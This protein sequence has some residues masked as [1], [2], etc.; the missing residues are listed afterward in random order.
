MRPLNRDT[1]PHL[2]GVAA[3][4]LREA[5]ATALTRLLAAWWGVELGDGCRFFGVPQF[6]R[7][8]GSTIRVGRECEFRSAPWSNQV[9]IDRGCYDSTLADGARVDLGDHSGFSGTVV[10][11]AAA[12]RIGSHVLCGANCT[13]TDTDWHP[14]RSTDRRDGVRGEASPVVIGDDVWLGLG[15]TVLKGA[16]IG[17]GT[18]VAAGSVVTGALPAGVVAAGMPAR[19]VRDLRQAS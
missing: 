16:S 13:I 11:A 19:V 7:H 5:S 12:I 2:T 10:A 17:A 18:V 3:D 15:V 6:R 9:G 8:P 14:I 4:L 1:L